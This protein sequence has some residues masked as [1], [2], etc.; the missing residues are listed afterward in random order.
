MSPLQKGPGGQN[1]RCGRENSAVS[2][3]NPR[4]PAILDQKIVGLALDHRQICG[5]PDRGLHRRRIQ[6]AIG[7]GARTAHGRALSAIQHLELDAAAVGNPAHQA[8]QSVDFPDQMALSEPADGRIAGHRADRRKSM[9]DERRGSAQARGSGRGLTA[10]V[11]AANHDHI[12]TL[13]HMTG[14][15]M[16]GSGSVKKHAGHAAIHG[17]GFT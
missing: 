8:V 5:F 16:E 10:G 11:A 13:I 1:H 9:G 4:N 7:L 6:L 12:E 3:P 17:R 2:Q 15:V 14:Y